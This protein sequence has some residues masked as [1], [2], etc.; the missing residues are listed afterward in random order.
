[1]LPSFARSPFRPKDP[2][3]PKI[4]TH[5]FN[6]N[7]IFTLE[8]PY[9]EEAPIFQTFNINLFV[10]NM[11]PSEEIKYR[12]RNET[13]KGKELSKLIENLLIEIKEKK[14]EYKDFKVLKSRDFNL[15]KSYGLIVLKFKNYP[16]ILKLFIE[17]PESFVNPYDRGFQAS[18]IY[19]MGGG[20]N[21]YLVGFTRIKNLQIIRK[22]I[23]NN[24][25]L[26]KELDTPRKWFWTPKNNKWIVITGKNIGKKKFQKICLPGTYAIIADEIIQDKS[27]TIFNKED[28][29]KCLEICKIVGDRMDPHIDN[30]L[31]EKE[32]GKMVL[33]DTEYFPTL[34]G[35]QKEMEVKSYFKWYVKLGCKFLQDKYF[36]HKKTRRKVQFGN[37]KKT[38]EKL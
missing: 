19:I 37:R 29:K 11:L 4:Y 8:D 14:K 35:L 12:N 5:W 13:I 16:F 9:L 17:S 25:E 34:V 15:K 6:E 10:N 24:P 32:T 7:K 1:M 30:F 38:H 18:C 23:E 2:L 28:R 31:P 3:N 22:K 20:I 26:A 36:R 21:R 27:F 33:I